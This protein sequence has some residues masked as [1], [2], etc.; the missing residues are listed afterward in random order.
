M[1]WLLACTSPPRDSRL[2]SQGPLRAEL[3]L[4]FPLAER[5]L[6]LETVGMDHDPQVHTGI[7]QLI[8]TAYDG[9]PF[10]A[11]YDEHRGSDYMLE[12]GFDVMDAGSAGV[13]AAADGVVVSVEDGNYDRCHGDASTFENDCDGYESKANHVILEHEGGWTT[14]YW[15]LM[16]D[17]VAVEP[18]QAVSCGELL[19]RVGSSGN[20]SAPHLHFQLED[21]DQVVVDP[22]AG[23][24]SQPETFWIEQGEAEGLPGSGC[25]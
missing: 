21:A 14:R 8:C 1:I 9:R 23:E 20:S 12:G 11:C 19:G 13:L 15:H 24:H 17:S 7:E 22:Y 3:Q 4:A 2:D 25:P 6:F 10:P 18:G 5:E 16:T